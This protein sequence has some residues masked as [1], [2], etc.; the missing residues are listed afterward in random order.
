M[1]PISVSHLELLSLLERKASLSVL[2]TPR[3]SLEGVA[4]NSVLISVGIKTRVDVQS[5]ILLIGADI[6]LKTT[7]QRVTKVC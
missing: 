7:M 1:Y 4:D 3:A 2:L 5:D 6:H